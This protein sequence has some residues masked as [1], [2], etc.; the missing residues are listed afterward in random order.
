MEPPHVPGITSTIASMLELFHDM[1]VNEGFE[2]GV[3]NIEEVTAAN[4]ALE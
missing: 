2:S 1:L 4:V 3:S